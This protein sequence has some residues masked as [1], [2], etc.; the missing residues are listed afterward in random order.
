MKIIADSPEEMKL[1]LKQSKWM[2]KFQYRNIDKGTGRITYRTLGTNNAGLFMKLY[3]TP[4][5]IAVDENYVKPEKI[6]SNRGR[7]KKI[8]PEI[9]LEEVVTRKRK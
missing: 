7:K 9:P 1:I 2:D 5:L 8:I 4:S 3:L 6:K